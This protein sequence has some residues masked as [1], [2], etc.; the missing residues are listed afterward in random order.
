MRQYKFKDW[1]QVDDITH[2]EVQGALQASFQLCNELS[3][4][5]NTPEERKHERA[6]NRDIETRLKNLGKKFKIT[7]FPEES[8]WDFKHWILEGEMPPPPYG[9]T[10][11]DYFAKLT[12]EQRQRF[13]DEACTLPLHHRLRGLFWP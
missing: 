13:M 1:G 2:D 12:K 8:T 6:R 10:L 11:G 3:K 9:F 7:E 4:F 5:F